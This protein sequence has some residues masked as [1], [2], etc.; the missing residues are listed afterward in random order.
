MDV[1]SFSCDK[2]IVNQFDYIIEE[3]KNC[4]GFSGYE[5]SFFFA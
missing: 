4:D 1:H 2:S 5:T 3:K